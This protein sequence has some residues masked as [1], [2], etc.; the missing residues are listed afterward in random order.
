MVAS[1]LVH[2]VVKAFTSH[3][4]RLLFPGSTGRVLEIKFFII[5]FTD[6]TCFFFTNVFE[7]LLCWKIKQIVGIDVE[8]MN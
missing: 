3:N 4:S 6:V 7:N 8:F 2:G 1:L 5:L